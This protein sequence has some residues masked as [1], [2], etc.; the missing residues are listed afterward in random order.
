MAI[1]QEK[2]AILAI[3]Q[4]KFSKKGNISPQNVDYS[5]SMS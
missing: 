2:D 5:T 3:L 4:S 1:T